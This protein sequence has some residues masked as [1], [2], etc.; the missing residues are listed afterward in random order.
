MYML[1]LSFFFLAFLFVLL[2]LFLALVV[3]INLLCPFHCYD[4][5]LCFVRLLFGFPFCIVVQF[6][7]FTFSIHFISFIDKIRIIFT[8]FTFTLSL[9]NVYF[10]LFSMQILTIQTNEV[11]TNAEQRYIN[12]YLLFK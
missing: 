5:F 9:H 10:E 8:I 11:D 3:L 7:F 6:C 4:R 2:V 12:P 1:G